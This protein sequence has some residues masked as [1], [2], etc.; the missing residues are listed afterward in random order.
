[1]KKKRSMTMTVKMSATAAAILRFMDMALEEVFILPARGGRRPAPCRHLT[2]ST[3]DAKAA[4]WAGLPTD[5]LQKPLDALLEFLEIDG[6]ENAVVGAALDYLVR[7]LHAI[8][9]N[10]EY[11][12]VLCAL[13]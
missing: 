1:M 9:G 12:N 3:E 7:V 4:P 6:F 5:S 8:G 13:V 2:Q 11:L 10:G